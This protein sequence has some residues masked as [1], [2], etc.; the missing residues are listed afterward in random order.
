MATIKAGTYRFKDVLT[1]WGD[2]ADESAVIDIPFTCTYNDIDETTYEVAEGTYQFN[3]L[4]VEVGGSVGYWYND[5]RGRFLYTADRG[6]KT[7]YLGFT[8]EE[9]LTAYP[10]AIVNLAS[11][12]YG[13]GIK[14]ITI[15]EDTDVSDKFGVCFTANVDPVVEE[16][17]VASV[18]YNGE[19]VI[20]LTAGQNA[21][22]A[23]AGKIMEADMV[24]EVAENVGG[25][26]S[27]ECDKPHVIEVTELPTENIDESAVY[28]CGGKFYKWANEFVDIIV[29]TGVAMSYKELLSGSPVE[30]YSFSIIPTKATDDVLVSDME[31][32]GHFYYIEDEADVFYYM[33][34]WYALSELGMTNGGVISDISEATEDAHYYALMEKGWKAY[35]NVSGELKITENGTYEVTDKACVVV[36]MP[37][38]AI[39][40]KWKFN[41]Y[42]D[43]DYS[44]IDLP[45]YGDKDFV[46]KVNFTCIYDGEV[47]NMTEIQCGHNDRYGDTWIYFV[48]ADGNQFGADGYGPGSYWGGSGGNHNLSPI[49]DFGTEPQIIPQ[50]LKEY[51]AVVAAQQEAECQHEVYDSQTDYVHGVYL[52]PKIARPTAEQAS[53]LDDGYLA[54]VAQDVELILGIT[55]LRYETMQISDSVSIALLNIR[56]TPRPNYDISLHYVWEEDVEIAKMVF[57]SL[58]V[59]TSAVTGAGWQVLTGTAVR[60]ISDE[61]LRS[62]D[63]SVVDSLVTPHGDYW[64]SLFEFK[65]SDSKKAAGI[66]KGLGG[67][68]YALLAQDKLCD[69]DIV[70]NPY[71]Y[72]NVDS[73]NKDGVSVDTISKEYDNIC[74]I[75]VEII[76][77]KGGSHF[78]VVNYA[79]NQYGTVMDF[80]IGS[81]LVV[82]SVDGKIRYTA[83]RGNSYGIAVK[84]TV[85]GQNKIK[86]VH[87]NATIVSQ[88]DDE[89]YISGLRHNTHIV[90]MAEAVE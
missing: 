75:D 2:V 32:C 89:V 55:M 78:D 50:F 56:S 29:V 66:L 18:S 85:S 73:F 34:D 13:E 9:A 12:V 62:I 41:V 54:E 60:T 22:L 4:V 43:G 70:V 19:T 20:S 31:S 3:R 40:G 11:V 24:V 37:S 7:Q 87:T 23:C 30:Q 28:A 74:Y 27:G 63:F 21:T 17:P 46:A 5:E 47:R 15:T 64:Y 82:N 68:K 80:E 16:T 65:V 14:T 1:L 72:R 77:G 10:E 59:D 83:S 67:G 61:E 86:S 8:R 90:V 58:G 26:G 48:D 79:I 49:I 88:S 36:D 51:M 45:T 71:G 52:K 6:W 42:S 76:G 69:R 84:T 57:N 35:A 44:Y 25:G 53:L 39:V 81:H 33:G 38:E